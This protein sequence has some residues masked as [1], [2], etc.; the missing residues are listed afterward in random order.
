M[1]AIYVARNQSVADL[2][3]EYG[4]GSVAATS[5]FEVECSCGEAHRLEPDGSTTCDCGELVQS[6]LIREGPI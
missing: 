1:D 3:D 2:V 4:V 6:P 5:V